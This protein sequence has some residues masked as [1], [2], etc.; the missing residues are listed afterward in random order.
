MLWHA[1][2]ALIA[3]VHRKPPNCKRPRCAGRR[4]ARSAAVGSQASEAG[5]SP[6]AATE[7]CGF[8][9]VAIH[10]LERAQR[11]L[12]AA[13]RSSARPKKVCNPTARWKFPGSLH[14]KAMAFLLINWFPHLGGMPLY[15]FARPIAM[16]DQFPIFEKVLKKRSRTWRWRVC[17]TEGDVVMQGSE[18]SRPAAK[19][20]ADR[21]LFL[22]LL[23]AP[24]RSIRLS[25]LP[26]P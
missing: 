15:G 26:E 12:A 13:T 20:K 2:E 25:T 7:R 6:R 5:H 23:S 10:R 18:S 17:T 22:L 16:P 4:P 14:K 11:L 9:D 21:A 3:R 24:Y 1:L 8:P 19:Y